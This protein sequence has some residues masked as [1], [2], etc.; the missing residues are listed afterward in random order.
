MKYVLS[1]LI[2]FS[3][4]QPMSL[5]ACDM[6]KDNH[7]G[8][9]QAEVEQVKHDCCDPGENVLEHQCA[10]MVSCGT[11]ALGLTLAVPESGN[12][13][14]VLNQGLSRPGDP[15]LPASHSSPP[16]RPPIA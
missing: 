10:D 12:C 6:D 14:F 2:V 3:V 11:C 1:L 13:R 16:F 8:H 4:L 5:Q 7:A 9:Q 15:S